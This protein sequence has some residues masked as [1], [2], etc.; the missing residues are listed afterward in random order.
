[1][2]EADPE[3]TTH[4]STA[5]TLATADRGPRDQL[6]TLGSLPA[7]REELASERYD[8]VVVQPG[9]FPP[10]HWQAIVRSLF[11]RSALR[12]VMPYF[13]TFGQQMIRGHVSAPIAIWDWEDS[14]FVF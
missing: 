12:G 3:T 11:R 2:R 7:L 10:W 8:L 13:R 9:P 1:M 5:P 14:P 6:G 4:W